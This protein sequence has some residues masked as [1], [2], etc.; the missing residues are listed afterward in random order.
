[1]KYKKYL[2][3][4]LAGTLVVSSTPTNIF[5]D[6]SEQQVEKQESAS[7]S[8]VTG[9]TKKTAE[10]E[11]T[12]AAETEA[13][14]TETTEAAE[15]EAAETETAETETVETET[16]ETETAETETTE[17]ETAETETT[18]T[19]TAE[20][21]TTETETAETET[22][23]TETTETE[24]AETKT[25][26]TE[27]TENTEKSENIEEATT[28]EELP[29]KI[30]LLETELLEEELAT[31]EAPT[32]SIED[33]GVINQTYYA[34][35][36][37]VSVAIEVP[38]ETT[39]YYTTDGTDPTMSDTKRLYESGFTVESSSGEAETVIIKAVAM[40][41]V[42]ESTDTTILY[43][44]VIIKEVNFIAEIDVKEPTITTYDSS[45]DTQESYSYKSSVVVEI[46]VPF[47]TEVFFTTDGTNPM[48]SDT[49]QL[50]EGSFTEVL[51][52][53]AY[54]TG[55]TTQI[56][57]VTRVG[58]KG[59]DGELVYVY[60]DVV[61]GE[62][63]FRA[64]VAASYAKIIATVAGE[65]RT[66]KSMSNHLRD[67]ENGEP[68]TIEFTHTNAPSSRVLYTLDG[69]D[70]SKSETAI[71]YQ[72]PFAISAS[73]LAAEKVELKVVVEVMDGTE[74][75]YSSKRTLYLY[76]LA[77]T[78]PV[79]ELS[80]TKLENDETKYANTTEVTATITNY[81]ENL[82]YVYTLDGTDPTL[83]SS[84]YDS[85]IGITGVKAPSS[86]GGKVEIKA[87]AV[88][89]GKY[90]SDITVSEVFFKAA[91]ALELAEGS[92]IADFVINC[93]D[94]ENA[95]LNDYI[96]TKDIE[97]H[98]DADGK[99]NLTVRFVEKNILSDNTDGFVYFKEAKFMGDS[100]ET[101]LTFKEP[102][103]MERFVYSSVYTRIIKTVT[104]PLDSLS[105]DVTIKFKNSSN[106]W[107]NYVLTLNSEP[108]PASEKTIDNSVMGYSITSSPQD[109]T[110]D[111][112]RQ[113]E[114]A[115]G[116]ALKSNGYSVTRPM[117]YYFTVDDTE[118]IDFNS[119][120]TSFPAV[121]SLEVAGNYG[122]WSEG[123]NSGKMYTTS[124]DP[125]TLNVRVKGYAEGLGWTDEISI[126]MKFNAKAIK[127]KIY[128]E[129][130]SDFYL[131][132]TGAYSNGITSSTYTIPYDT[133]FRVNTVTEEEEV[134]KYAD[135][136]SEVN[137]EHGNRNMRVLD[138]IFETPDGEK[139]KVL[140]QTGEIKSTTFIIP[141]AEGFK[142]K[143][144]TLYKITEN[145]TKAELIPFGAG[146][147][148]L[149]Y[150]AYELQNEYPGGVYVVVAG[151]N[152]DMPSMANGYY[153]ASA[154]LKDSDNKYIDNEYAD[155]LDSNYSNGRS[156]LD[157][158]TYSKYMYLPLTSKG[159]EYVTDFYYYDY[160]NSKY[161]K[162][163]AEETYTVNGEKYVKL[164]KIPITTKKAY[165]DVYFTTSAGKTQYGTLE[166]DYNNAIITTGIDAQAPKMTTATGAISYVNDDKATV[167]L[168]TASEGAKIYYT[169][170]SGTTGA[171]PD[172]TKTQQL[173]T[174]PIELSTANS[175]GEIYTIRAVTVKNG[176]I[177]SDIVEYT[178]TFN[179]KG[180]AAETAQKPV[181]YAKYESGETAQDGIYTVTITSKTEDTLLY[182]TTDGSVPS[183]QNGTL[184]TESF[185]VPALTDGLPTVVKA[186]AEG[187]G[188]N[189]SEIAETE[190]S[191]SSDWWDN[192]QVGTS[193]EI[194]I[195]MLN[196]INNS[197]LSMG[198]GALK[199]NAT[200]YVDENGDK[201]LTIPFQRIDMG[202][203]AG[204][205]VDLWYFESEA[206][207]TAATWKDDL[208]MGSYEYTLDD[209]IG[210]VTIPLFHNGEKVTIGI[211]SNYDAMGRQR[212]T[213]A[214]DYSD[215]IEAVTGV[216]VEKE[217]QVD[218]PTIDAVLNAAG[219]AMAI[220]I[221][222]PS[223]SE[224]QDAD[225]YYVISG[226]DE[227]IIEK[228]DENK[229]LDTFVITKEQ[230]AEMGGTADAV[231]VFA[232]ATKTDYK[233]SI[234]N[235]KKLTFDTTSTGGDIVSDGEVDVTQDGK[236]WVDIDLYKE[237]DDELSMGNVAFE[238]NSRALIV[239]SGGKSVIQ[240][241]SNPVRIPP[242]YSALE[243]FQFKNAQGVYQLATT[244]ETEEISTT[245]MGVDYTF[246]YLKKFEFTLPSVTDKYIDVKVKVPYTIMDS[247]VGE[248]AIPARLKIDWSSMKA[249]KDSDE[250]RANSSASESSVSITSSAVDI[251]D[252]ETGIR[253][254]APENVLL[255]GATLYSSILKEGSQFKL[256]QKALGEEVGKFTVFRILAKVNDEEISPLENVKLYIPIPEDYDQERV[257]LYRINEDGT[258]TLI[259]G[260]AAQGGL[261]PL[262]KSMEPVYFEF[263]TDKFGL[264][265]L[266]ETD[267]IINVPVVTQAIQEDEMFDDISGH[268]AKAY[269]EK[270]VEMG[271]FSG[272]SEESF[273][274]DVKMTRGMFVTILGKM[275]GI[276]PKT[277]RGS[278]FR[279][280]KDEDYYSSYV[281]WAADMGIAGGVGDGTFAPNTN[282]TREQMAVMFTKYAEI[283][284]VN[285][286]TS[287]NDDFVD[288][289]AISH[290]AMSSVKTLAKAGVISGRENR[291]FTPK[292]A[293]SR[294]EVASMIVRF[295]EQYMSL[296]IEDEQET[297]GL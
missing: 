231:N 153:L 170:I 11:T 188:V 180:M 103:E 157:I 165:L 278:R 167:T 59:E 192:I 224:V 237:S 159:G 268:W 255:E 296:Q 163:T 248:N 94:E 15:T 84:K 33:G 83:E 104:V 179:Q 183:S 34:N 51:P 56:K 61:E 152:E 115:I 57:A 232:V 279:D 175:E 3:M 250:L 294:A 49:R 119:R 114:S 110:Y 54:M 226:D 285:F 261:I 92:Y 76:F 2:T 186:I 244:L 64:A 75:I 149:G 291:S 77:E 44:Q 295:T 245:Y 289:N 27:E 238:N 155:I 121:D 156:V 251:T 35:N 80:L 129:N 37:A 273:G 23:E 120:S 24:T 67:I 106:D 116:I 99:M 264:F 199:G 66:Y 178:I 141:E 70:P 28:T 58:I 101:D 131:T 151:E 252:S 174:G 32:I 30:D 215:V 26:E 271:I 16:A 18:E 127:N 213:L 191:F 52:F 68:V 118:E 164:A 161:V 200:L 257:A 265:A 218:I 211:E 150:G 102:T 146:S 267:E 287:G 95:W 197:L 288:R 235:V 25:A 36:A 260:T 276:K 93:D 282:I 134:K 126:P 225:I 286:K 74:E 171:D 108:K 100:G 222:M 39:V 169:C 160:E 81:D 69:S 196:Y 239:T 9:E 270:A 158:R 145:G 204:Y 6:T 216:E 233:D 21:E 86:A 177:T 136:I 194:P 55:G 48:E 78:I 65:S 172:T 42:G 85:G 223:A 274:P 240:I 72:E 193:Y 281:L 97:I 148:E 297:N 105:T 243:E 63:V 143:N 43:S 79:P 259:R 109:V 88:K 162:A 228:T 111:G 47:N 234:V 154:K 173:Y 184:Y 283:K 14:E 214:L 130:D 96:D 229:Y 12:E 176:F 144:V 142:V 242:Y 17:M 50:Y 20:T 38:E 293:A 258:K 206:V 230:A 22:A 249:G 185:R 107:A 269:I 1:M 195:K 40:Q 207:A 135:L 168:S 124:D 113:T 236:Y 60:S 219:D 181:I 190:I 241:G 247:A 139:V 246:D 263:E 90:L 62:V 133:V 46:D 254:V 45:G 7:Q 182:Y 140:D 203:F 89:D 217:N 201:F 10:T 19:E 202:G 266:V 137:P 13:A 253:L 284:G 73:S 189:A 209:K 8:E 123:S 290:W 112:Y 227:T 280:V 198:N 132:L 147:T 292:D 117:V 256:A 4:F 29:E 82:E 5:A 220:T 166:L 138:Y 71:E 98:V 125:H 262:S 122:Q 208:M 210:S 275:D 221:S 31:V 187:T 212:A 53:E 277:Y 91:D 272:I 41:E 87:A 128:A 205:L